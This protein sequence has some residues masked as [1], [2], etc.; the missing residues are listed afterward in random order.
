MPKRDA[1]LLIEDSRPRGFEVRRRV[2][3][4]FCRLLLRS[5]TLG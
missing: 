1:D 3:G 2:S 4:A 5:E